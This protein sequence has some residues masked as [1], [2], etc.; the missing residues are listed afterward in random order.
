MNGRAF[1][2][3]GCSMGGFGSFQAAMKYPHV[4]NAIGGFNSP[5]YPQECHFGYTCHH[6]CATNMIL[7]ELVFTSGNQAMNAYVILFA[8]SLVVSTSST[9]PISW[10]EAVHM[11]N[12]G[13]YVECKYTSSADLVGSTG[14]LVSEFK[15]GS[16]FL[17]I[18]D[19]I[20]FGSSRG[21]L[22]GKTVCQYQD[23]DEKEH[24][25]EIN[26]NWCTELF[27]NVVSVD[28]GMMSTVL[29]FGGKGETSGRWTFDT[30]L[31]YEGAN[32]HFDCNTNSCHS[33]F[34]NDMMPYLPCY[35]KEGI[36]DGSEGL[37]CTTGSNQ[38][39][40]QFHCADTKWCVEANLATT[41][42]DR[43]LNGV[44]VTASIMKFVTPYHPT[45]NMPIVSAWGRQLFT[46]PSM[47]IK[48][49]IDL[50]M[51]FTLIIFLHCSQN[52]E[53]LLFPM[54]IDLTS[55]LQYAS[56]FEVS[57][58]ED[59]TYQVSYAKHTPAFNSKSRFV[60]D[61][62]DCDYHHFSER[63][64]KMGN[65]FFADA[66]RGY[67]QDFMGMGIFTTRNHADF[68]MCW[69]PAYGFNSVYATTGVL[70]ACI[71]QWY[72]TD[73]GSFYDANGEFANVYSLESWGISASHNTVHQ[74]TD[75]V[76]DMEKEAM[77]RVDA[78]GNPCQESI[79]TWL[80]EGF[81]ASGGKAYSAWFNQV[82]PAHK[83]GTTGTD[84]EEYV[85]GEDFF[86]YEDAD[87]DDMMGDGYKPT[88]PESDS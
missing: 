77:T 13:G 35:H 75:A 81:V 64:M 86:V 50:W 44:A 43:Y 16:K 87:F 58:E 29:T 3:F 78:H 71:L 56:E 9:D 24:Y 4:V 38:L 66:L 19:E 36:K 49:K 65:L 53:F 82:N 54:F 79:G 55:M 40:S 33:D 5:I 1:G 21:G 68:R 11:A 63:D 34:T 48:H 22:D 20:E 12:N 27:Q 8:G 41:I 62:G 69:M 46:M 76:K 15:K 18:S 67:T 2:L 7:C 72:G 51:D 26:E 47:L 10:G 42:D 70:D 23:W 85:C 39:C 60:V 84:E 45:D 61:F 83:P 28:P 80:V 59:G 52:D 6:V 74:D 37:G 31:N 57:F 25:S 32:P 30:S 17:T 88:G 73:I 14:V